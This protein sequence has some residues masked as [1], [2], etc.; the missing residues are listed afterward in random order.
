[1][2][3]DDRPGDD[4]APVVPAARAGSRDRG[5]GADR[6]RGCGEA[7]SGVVDLDLHGAGMHD[8]AHDHRSTGRRVADGVVDQVEQDTRNL[9]H[10]VPLTKLS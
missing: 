9:E 2:R 10:G 5:P 3:L 6:L 1:M 7:R 4:E 8:G